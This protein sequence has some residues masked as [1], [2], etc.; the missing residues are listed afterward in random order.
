M[1]NPWAAGRYGLASQRSHNH[2]RALRTLGRAWARIIWR[3]WTTRTPYDPERHAGLQRHITVTIPGSS[4]PRPGPAATQWM[5]GAT[6]TH[7]AGRRAQRAAL[8]GKPASAI[9]ARR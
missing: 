5:A 2:R 9:S 7:R 3:C 4:G 8:D 6:V 1:W